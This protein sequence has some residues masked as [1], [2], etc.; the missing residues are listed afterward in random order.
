MSRQAAATLDKPFLFTA[1]TVA[2]NLGWMAA[3]KLSISPPG[4]REVIA[5]MSRQSAGTSDK[6]FFFTTSTVAQSLGWLRSNVSSFLVMPLLRKAGMNSK[7][8]AAR[9]SL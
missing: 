3:G 9:L 4:Q 1:Y 7:P 8:L 6:P 2:E 5:A